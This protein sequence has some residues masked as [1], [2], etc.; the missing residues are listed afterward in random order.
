[1]RA[2]IPG[3]GCIEWLLERRAAMADTTNA[4]HP[5]PEPDVQANIEQDTL[6]PALDLD[7]F[8]TEEMAHLH[9]LRE[10]IAS[11]RV[12]ELTGDYRRLLFARWLYQQGK[13]EG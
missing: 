12:G 13:I 9:D 5:R 6:L 8:S 1:M 10:R 2:A 4:Q 3:V 11:G 7:L